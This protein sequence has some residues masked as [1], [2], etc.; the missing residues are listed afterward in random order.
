[1]RRVEIPQCRCLAGVARDDITPPVGIYHRMWGA[2]S[3][4]RSTGVHRP[5][6]ATVLYLANPAGDASPEDSRAIVALD[7]CML[8]KREMDELVAR[9]SATAQIPRECIIVFFSHTHGAGLMGLERRQLPGGDLIPKYLEDLAARIGMLIQK[10]RKKKQP[11]RIGFGVGRCNMA[12]N[13][14][15]FD[16]N[17][18]QFVCGFNP[19]GTADDRLLVGR[20]S[21]EKNRTV[22]T[23]VNYA[24]HPTT[25]AWE[26]TLISPDYVGAMR[27]TLEGATGAPCVF[28]QGASGDIG[29]RDGF[30]ADVAVAD[31]NGRQLGYAALSALESIP[32]PGLSYE[33]SGPVI[34]G[35][36]LGIWEYVPMAEQRQE[37]LA[38]FGAE[39]FDVPLPYRH[40]LPKPAELLQERAK[41]Q[42]REA[43][44]RSAGDTMRAADA[45]AKAE[46]VTRRLTRI[47]QLP[48]GDRF[49]LPVHL[50]RMGDSVWVGLNGEHYN[51]LQRELRGRFPGTPLIVGTL[52][53]GSEASYLLDKAA[54]GKGL[55]QEKVSLL[56]KGCLETLI[57]AIAGRI[58][59]LM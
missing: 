51:L 3:H 44:A 27:E 33:Y 43:H 28:I 57:D 14:D 46:R 36:T 58:E 45:R 39:R 9:V 37:A 20:L 26:N 22:A 42:E 4:D 19:E 16:E 10:A 5:L 32:D 11:G 18:Q 47:R 1:M 2:A 55:Y 53:N 48:P 52:A 21:D 8:G 34:S 31:R 7:H 59:K 35:A 40:D 24:C 6:T 12:A 54:Y 25:L 56:A 38:V 23:I 49:P 13:R 30:V 41:W 29:P 50:W 17:L 15:Y